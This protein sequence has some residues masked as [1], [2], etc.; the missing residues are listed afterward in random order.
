MSP[1]IDRRTAHAPEAA[2]AAACA[3]AAAARRP[4][5]P[6]A[7]QESHSEQAWFVHRSGPV[8]CATAAELGEVLSLLGGEA[9]RDERLAARPVP[10]WRVAKGMPLYSAGAAA[11]MLYVVRT[12]SFKSALMGED[13]VEQVLGF[14][15][16][17]EVL[18]FE[19]VALGRQPYSAIALEDSSVLGLPLAQVEGWRRESAVLD[20]ALQ[21]T[22][23][24]QFARMGLIAGLA[25]PVSAEARLARFVLWLSAWMEAK[26]QSPRRLL[27]RMSRRD[28]ASLLA[29]AHETVSRSLSQLVQAGWLEVDGRDIVILDAAGLKGCAAR[30]RR[31]R[32]ETPAMPLR[33]APM[34]PPHA[35]AAV[36]MAA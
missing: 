23:S 31:E 14:V 9:E 1:R 2:A 34:M 26:G 29:V 24:A 17:G 20:A 6:A 16:A 8:L 15:G 7:S 5:A 3:I 30:S 36:A 28:I 19:G 33:P 21:R 35:A 27:L 12:G 25:A 10:M 11:Q 18:G 13:G 32:D 22:L 4:V